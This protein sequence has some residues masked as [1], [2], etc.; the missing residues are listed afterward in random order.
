MWG[1]ANSVRCG[2]SCLGLLGAAFGP[3]KSSLD[4]KSL[5]RRRFFF[6][7]F[8]KVSFKQSECVLLNCLAKVCCW[9]YQN[10][11]LPVVS[12]GF[13]RILLESSYVF[14]MHFLF[15]AH[16]QSPPLSQKDG[17]EKVLEHFA[18]AI[19]RELPSGCWE[20]VSPSRKQ[21]MAFL[22]VIPWVPRSSPV[23]PKTKW[24]WA[25]TQIVPP[26]NIPIQ[27]LKSPKMGGAP[28]SQNGIPTRCR[29]TFP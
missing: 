13:C 9:V 26:A 8:L 28:T 3:Y 27:P 7:F 16:F 23:R 6:S 19:G 17:T 22:R 14:R 18:G 11:P 12:A 10:R 21:G 2:R 15:G 25:K 4:S 24:P 29:P 1:V 5:E 20:C